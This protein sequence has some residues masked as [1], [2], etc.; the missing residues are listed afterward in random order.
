MPSKQQY[1]ISSETLSASISAVSQTVKSLHERMKLG[2]DNQ[3]EIDRYI[4]IYALNLIK[5]PILRQIDC[6]LLVLT[7]S[8]VERLYV[9]PDIGSCIRQLFYLQYY[10]KSGLFRIVQYS[11]PFLKHNRL[12]F[13]KITE[14][15]TSE[16]YDML[17]CM[18]TCLMAFIPNAS[19]HATF[20][21][22]VKIFSMFHDI[23]AEV[24]VQKI[25]NFCACNIQILRVAIMEVFV[26]FIQNYMP[27]EHTM[28]STVLPK[29]VN[30]ENV[31]DQIQISV[32]TFRQTCL[33]NDTVDWQVINSAAQL[34]NERCNRLC[35]GKYTFGSGKSKSS[36]NIQ[37][38][39]SVVIE[40]IH[41][42]VMPHAF[43]LRLAMPDHEANT[44]SSIDR[45]HQFVSIKS[46]PSNLYKMQCE[47]VRELCQE[48]T[49]VAVRSI[50]LHYCVFCK[51]EEKN[52]V[53]TLMRVSCTS[54][55]K[56]SK[57]EHSDCMIKINTMG[58]FVLIG[59][60]T[61]YFCVVC[62]KVHE[63][64][65]MGDAF[66]N[67]CCLKPPVQS[68]QDTKNKCTLCFRTINV[69]ALNVLDEKNGCIIAPKLCS[70]HQ[71]MVI[72]SKEVRTVDGL[73]AAIKHKIECLRLTPFKSR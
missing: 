71:P 41:A 53:D 14:F 55:V 24:D 46:M 25:L 3:K 35:K 59:K 43:Y 57:C 47:K 7:P 17:R 68:T 22:K 40:A 34:C 15:T 13:P 70:K 18:Q 8:Q 1:T 69:N 51:R 52:T 54:S 67:K 10:S 28:M 49:T 39:R 42:P 20:D 37:M 12:T 29:D 11:M 16:I 64:N 27:V 44:I 50:F 48:N 56:C 62:R 66:S 23:L 45:V 32:D 26:Y 2:E 5:S 9:I 31:M 33:Q 21:N 30:I 61:F 65:Q 4:L 19:K 38:D 58:R 63:W 6:N 73:T 72:S 36:S 60:N